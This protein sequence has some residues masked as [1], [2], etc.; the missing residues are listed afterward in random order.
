ML[1]DRTDAHALVRKGRARSALGRRVH[2]RLTRRAASA[3]GKKEALR[4]EG[5]LPGCTPEPRAS[6]GRG[7]RVGGISMDA[8][9]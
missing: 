2:A 5:R 8:V 7:V 3:G 4:R 6:R 1:R 9:P